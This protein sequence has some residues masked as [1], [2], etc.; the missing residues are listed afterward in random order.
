MHRP[1]PRQPG[2]GIVGIES[3]GADDRANEILTA[4]GP[5]RFGGADMTPDG[6]WLWAALSTES[7]AFGITSAPADGRPG[8]TT[9]IDLGASPG[10]VEPGRDHSAAEIQIQP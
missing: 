3:I 7:G 5:I 10:W 2:C 1:S 8:S 4:E 9:H 6:R